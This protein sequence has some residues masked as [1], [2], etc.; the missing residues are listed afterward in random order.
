MQLDGQQE[1]PHFN[2]NI[3][4]QMAN[5]L[6]SSLPP[7]QVEDCDLDDLNQLPG[8]TRK[9]SCVAGGQ[10]SFHS[11]P[12]AGGHHHRYDSTHQ[13]LPAR[14]S[15]NAEP[16][17]SSRPLNGEKKSITGL[18]GSISGLGAFGDKVVK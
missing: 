13:F 10:A 1:V 5:N 2:L 14:P 7:L 15:E 8:A 11:G 6:D 18:I 16:D 17:G 9:Q 3:D 12:G 4:D